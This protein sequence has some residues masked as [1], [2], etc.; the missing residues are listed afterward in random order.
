[1]AT[2]RG[3][4]QVFRLQLVDADS[5]VVCRFAA[6]GNI[7]VDLVAEAT[8][9]IQRTWL[10]PAEDFAATIKART[11]SF[12]G[13]TI[14]HRAVQEATATLASWRN[15]GENATDHMIASAIRRVIADLKAHMITVMRDRHGRL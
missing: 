2:E 4:V 7:E 14:T 6:G 12:C 11:P 10:P 1:M 3:G 8:K 15:T 9:E 13:L 5:N